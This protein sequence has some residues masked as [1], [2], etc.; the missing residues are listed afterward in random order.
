MKFRFAAARIFGLVAYAL[1]TVFL[2]AFQLTPYGDKYRKLGRVQIILPFT[3]QGERGLI[4][5]RNGNPLTVNV[6]YLKIYKACSQLSPSVVNSLIRNKDGQSEILFENIRNNRLHTKIASFKFRSHIIRELEKNNEVV[7]K[8][9]GDRYYP[10]GT[11]LAPLIGCLGED[12]NPLGGLELI[13]DPL[14]RGKPGKVLYMRDAMGNLIKLNENM[15]EDPKPGKSIVTTIN[16]LLQEFCY[17]A[18]KNR[19]EETGASRGFVVVTNPQTGEIL[20]L[21]SYPAFEPN[22]KIP[23][24]NIAVEDPY[25]PGSTFKLITYTCAL[26]NKMVSLQDTINTE[27]GKFY[28]FNHLIADEHPEPCMTVRD[29]FTY[30]SNIAAAKIGLM[31][32]PEKLFKTAQ[33]FGI[34]CPSG[35]NLP[36]ES[37]PALKRPST[38]GI[39]RTANFAYGYGVMVN[40]I[41]MAMAYGAVANG[42]YLLTPRILKNG[43]RIVVRRVLQDETVNILKEMLFDVVERGTGKKARVMGIQ[44]CGKTGTAKALDPETGKY[45]SDAMTSSFIGFF[46][47]DNPKYLI[48]VV[49]FEPK[50]PIYMRYGGEVAAPL[51]RQITEFIIGGYNAFVRTRTGSKNF[52]P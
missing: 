52:R 37:A 36:G 48:Y 21:A 44:I 26:E 3:I 4:Y 33:K 22:N 35:V 27:N 42:G 6:P 46:P 8:I 18:L 29:A 41:Q 12:E 28:L 34:G 39:L 14:V 24:K 13:F 19:I 20:A 5:D 31:L 49:I 40:G 11:T 7:Q 9:V 30:S 10:Y 51:F 25:E 16:L 2:F 38:W 32:G 1:L 45:S 47:K 23:S 50:G 17:I 15:D 43:K